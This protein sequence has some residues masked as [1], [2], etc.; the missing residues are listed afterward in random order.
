MSCIRGVSRK[1]SKG[2]MRPQKG[3]RGKM[4]ILVINVQATLVF[5][6]ISATAHDL[7]ILEVMKKMERV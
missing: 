3:K 6:S 2:R 4:K 1:K 7:P 5:P